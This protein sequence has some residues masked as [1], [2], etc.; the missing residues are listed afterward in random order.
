MKIRFNFEGHNHIVLWLCLLF[1]SSTFAL[2]QKYH[3]FFLSVIAAFES[4]DKAAIASLVY[5]PLKR[6]YPIPD[7]KD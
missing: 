1:T 5:Y 7:I 6:R 3:E 2:E 4:D